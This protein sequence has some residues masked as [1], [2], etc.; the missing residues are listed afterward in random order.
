MQLGTNERFAKFFLALVVALPTLISCGSQQE[1]GWRIGGMWELE[2]PS[3]AGAMPNLLTSAS[4]QVYLSWIEFVDDTTDALQYAVLDDG[5]WSAPTNV[6]SG[7]DWFVNWA[8]FPSL[9]IYS[10]DGQQMAAHWLQ[11]SAEG[12]YDY[13]VRITQSQ[14][15]GRHWAPAFV[16]HRDSVHAEHGFVTMLP[17]A[18]DRIFITWLDGRFT[19]DGNHENHKA[20]QGAMTLRAAEFD[21]L[22]QLYAEAE[23]DDRVC[24]CC[25]T[26]AATTDQGVIVAYRDR[27]MDEVRDVSVVRRVAGRWQSPQQVH[28]D[29]WQIAGCP[30]NGPAIDAIGSIVGVA[31]YT[32]ARDTPRVQIAFSHDAGKSFSAPLHID[33]GDPLGRVDMVLLSGPTAAVTWMERTERAAEIRLA[34]I[35]TNGNVTQQLTIGSADASRSSGFPR[36]VHSGGDLVVAWTNV[37]DDSRRVASA[38]VELKRDHHE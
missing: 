9:A 11:M 10:G 20:G 7:T 1:E 6:V 28:A 30:V 21:I 33:G 18:S 19:K 23:L 31:W 14:D 12:T 36:L 25:Q 4:G 29:G 16:P 3:R 26:S 2:V 37:V 27:S 17:L 34:L 15:N 38:Y 35:P 8:D 32:E 24:D 13:D 5:R 22:G